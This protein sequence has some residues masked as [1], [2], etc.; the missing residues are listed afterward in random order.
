MLAHELR[1]GRDRPAGRELGATAV[2]SLLAS[3]AAALDIP[4]PAG[5]GDETIF[6]RVR[7]QRATAVL[8]TV[9][10][11]LAYEG[12][13]ARDALR[14]ALEA[15]DI[16]NAATV[17]GQEARDARDRSR[18]CRPGRA[19]PARRAAARRTQ[20]HDLPGRRCRPGA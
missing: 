12:R 6:P 7:S 18:L 11:V 14:A 13:T 5:P 3:I 8:R 19:H 9:A 16:P 4:V 10:D 15:L 17:G 2:R 20:P 1:L